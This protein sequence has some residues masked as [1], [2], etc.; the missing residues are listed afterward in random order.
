MS[1]VVSR[2]QVSAPYNDVESHEVYRVLGYT[3]E[4]ET[5]HAWVDFSRGFHGL[6][7]AACGGQGCAD[8]I[9]R[10]FTLEPGD[11]S[12]EQWALTVGLGGDAVER[13]S[14]VVVLRAMAHAA[15]QRPEELQ[16][17]A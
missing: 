12:V 13:E 11:V 17:V 9:V 7:C 15:T 4:T 2:I 10:E 5:D 1:L 6:A 14:A 8:C 16:E 3:T